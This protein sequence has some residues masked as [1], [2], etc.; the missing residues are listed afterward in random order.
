MALS[1]F[2]S[3]MLL[4]LLWLADLACMHFMMPMHATAILNSTMVPS[5]TPV[6]K[7]I[8]LCRRL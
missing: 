2:G 4:H 6:A 1:V 3:S 5:P 7:R 8:I